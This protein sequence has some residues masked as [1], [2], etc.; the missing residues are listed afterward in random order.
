M[1]ASAPGL[2]L[3]G[4]QHYSVLGVGLQLLE[5]VIEIAWHEYTVQIEDVVERDFG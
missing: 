1:L 4:Q 5:F 3:L 2:A